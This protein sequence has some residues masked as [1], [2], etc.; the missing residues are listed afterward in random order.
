M[1]KGLPMS[2]LARI[3]TGTATYQDDQEYWS[4]KP[5]PR[6]T[7]P[8][9]DLD[10][11]RRR[12][13]SLAELLE[14]RGGFKRTVVERAL[15][16]PR[17]RSKEKIALWLRAQLKELRQNERCNGAAPVRRDKMISRTAISDAAISM[18][19]FLEEAPCNNLICLTMELLEVDRHRAAL[20]KSFGDPFILAVCEEA[21]AALTGE[22]FGVRELA[23][24]I[25][26]EPSTV[27]RW[28]RKDIYKKDVEE[29]KAVYTS[30]LRPLVDEFLLNS[31]SASRREAY[32]SAFGTHERWKKPRRYR[33][34]LK[35]RLA[36]AGSLTE[37]EYIF[38]HHVEHRVDFHQIR[39]SDAARLSSMFD[40][41]I[42]ELTRTRAL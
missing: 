28:R 3:W 33:K 14:T 25:S 21:K 11:F 20:A 39:L 30:L 23:R 24:R 6:H 32:K 22:A 8:D 41:R 27:L 35:D 26:V 16:G 34:E 2:L 15:T 29:Q 19:Q 4:S 31:P 10:A 13:S 17:A 36:R 1:N 5:W 38:A 7:F 18:L 9:G 12:M 42:D 40:G 37:V